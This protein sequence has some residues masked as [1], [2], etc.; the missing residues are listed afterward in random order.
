MYKEKSFHLNSLL[1]VETPDTLK[2]IPPDFFW[3]FQSFFCVCVCGG[4]GRGGASS[5]MI[6]YLFLAKSS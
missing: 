3:T 4:E 5:F 2:R 6:F 1:P